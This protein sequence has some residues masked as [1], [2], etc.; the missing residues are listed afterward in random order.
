MLRIFSNDKTTA[1]D[2]VVLMIFVAICILIG[3]A[4]V[5]WQ[6]NTST[7][8]FGVAICDGSV[9]K[10]LTDA[11]CYKPEELKLDDKV[12]ICIYKNMV[13]LDDFNDEN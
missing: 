3:V 4:G 7:T 13:L 10:Y 12:R 6:Y 11:N 1:K 8:V 5:I 9:T 2:E